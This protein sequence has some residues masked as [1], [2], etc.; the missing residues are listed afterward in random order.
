MSVENNIFLM[1]KK[2]DY[3]DVIFEKF[4]NRNQLEIYY[5]FVAKYSI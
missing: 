5:E 4:D 1:L 2:Y 3:L